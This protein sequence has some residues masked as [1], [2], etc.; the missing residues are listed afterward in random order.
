MSEKLE[1]PPW[2]IKTVERIP[3]LTRRE[4]KCAIERAG[5]NTFLLKSREV[6]VDLLTDSGTNA[7]YKGQCAAMENADEAYAGSE[8][9][10]RLEGVVT[11]LY[12][13]RHMKPT[14]QGRAAEAIAA[15]VLVSP[16]QHVLS[17]M[18]FTTSRANVED[19][20]GVWDDVSVDEAHD[21]QNLC[22]FKGNIDIEKLER[23]IRE[24]GRDQIAFIRQEAS[25]NM[26]GGQ[27]FSMDNL[28]AVKQIAR[29]WDIPFLIDATRAIENSYFLIQRS[30]EYRRKRSIA[31]ILHEICSDAD[32]VIVSAKKDAI[33]N[34][35][36]FFCTNDSIHF[37]KAKG[38]LVMKWGGLDYGGL[39]GEAM[40]AIATGLEHAVDFRYIAH[41][42]SQVHY[43][44]QL[45]LDA[46]IPV[47]VPFGGHAIYLDAKRFLPDVP[48][49]Q[50]TAQTLA[51]EIYIECGVRSM[52][53]GIAS[54]GKDPATGEEHVSELELV[55]L[56]IPR[57][58][59]GEEHFQYV[60]EGIKK[61]YARRNKI[62]RGLKMSYEPEILRFFGARFERV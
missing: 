9:F 41:R 57:M 62:R 51:A 15:H 42:V 4:R 34:I 31:R 59:Y 12:G 16:G 38:R 1:L 55:R 21:P 39:S 24:L 49:E 5:F 26:A 56:T 61:L 52:E 35:G 43:L 3:I 44:G 6:T 33:V 30:K 20:G 19:E 17:N 45:L 22:I 40:E 48:Q 60:A 54:A 10:E 29:R 8:S 7:M 37:E 27:P 50:Y 23:K 25:L 46:G 11:R 28:R 18:Y 47:V 53:R 32:W 36:G 14:N 2:R 58:V 13:L